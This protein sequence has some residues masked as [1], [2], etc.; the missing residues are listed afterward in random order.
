MHIS[1]GMQVAHRD[2][3]IASLSSQ[4]AE[5]QGIVLAQRGEHFADEN[6]GHESP[7]PG[8]RVYNNG[9]PA[10]HRQRVCM[11]ICVCVSVCLYTYMYVCIHT[12]MYAI[13]TYIHVCMH[14][15]IHTY[16]HSDAT[17]LGQAYIRMR[18]RACIVRH[19]NKCFFYISATCTC[20][21][22][23]NKKMSKLKDSGTAH[24]I[25]SWL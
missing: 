23:W 17:C 16:I 10:S 7:G 20:R 8:I 6:F 14:T 1:H 5:L 3:Y 13:H 21:P 2:R 22:R 11:Y 24:N 9:T 18:V 15:Y 19:K 12:Y 25:W 4:V